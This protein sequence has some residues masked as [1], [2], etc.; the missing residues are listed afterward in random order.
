MIALASDHAGYDY[1]ERIK[2]LLDELKVPY[3]DFGTTSRDSTDYPD[4]AHAAATSVSNGECDRGILICGT[5]IGMSIT[6]NKH[7][8]VRAAVCE[9]VTAARLARQHNNANVL[10]IGERI[11]CW[12]SAVDIIKTFLFT[13]FEGGRHGRRVE[14]IHTLTSL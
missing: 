3:K 10:T 7:K 13:P 5:G 8:G 12:E 11:T 9:S 14:K 1:K 4:W 6:A 2:P